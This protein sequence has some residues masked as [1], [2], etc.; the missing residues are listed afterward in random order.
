M[1]MCVHAC[2][3][4]CVCTCTGYVH[5]HVCHCECHIAEV[6]VYDSVEAM[7]NSYVQNVQCTCS[8]K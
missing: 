4:V 8:C 1:S 3:R 6:V 2:M 5:V 7:E